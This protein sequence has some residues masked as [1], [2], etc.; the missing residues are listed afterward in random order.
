MPAGSGEV[1]LSYHYRITDSREFAETDLHHEKIPEHRFGF[2]AR[3]DRVLGY[4]IEATWKTMG[5]DMAGFSNQELLNLG[6]DY[7]FAVGN[8]LTVVYEQLLAAF[9]EK[10]FRF[11]EGITFSLLNATYP[12]GLFNNIS[13]I[14]YFDWRNKNAYNFVN[15]QKQFNRTTVHL[16]GYI[17]PK[18]YQIPTVTTT[19]ILFTG[20]GM[21]V[22]LVFNH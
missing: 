19:D 7:T 10:P 9:D 4:W 13:Y 16:M 12:V 11:S 20:T 14:L 21:Q 15:W 6:L 2:D 1:A 18:N 17:N 5:R 8:G 22:M 3:F